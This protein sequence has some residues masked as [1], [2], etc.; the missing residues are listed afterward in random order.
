MTVEAHG[1]KSAWTAQMEIDHSRSRVTHARLYAGALYVLSDRGM[2]AAYDAET[3]KPLWDSAKQIGDPS[4]ACFEPAV[5]ENLLALVNGTRLYVLNRFNGEVLWDTSLTG[6]PATGP[7][8]SEHRVYVPMNA[9]LVT[10]YLLKPLLDPVKDLGKAKAKPKVAEPEPELLSRENFKLAQESGAVL[11]CQSTGDPTSAPVV[12]HKVEDDVV[13]W[14]TN[15]GY[16]FISQ[17]EH[18]V[19]D[20]FTTKFR[21]ETGAGISVAPTYLPPRTSLATRDR[22]II[23]AVSR[24]GR[25]FSIDEKTGE[26]LWQ[27]DAVDPIVQSAAALGDQVFV[28]T[29]L[30]GMHCLD[31][32]SGAQKWWAPD[33][34]QF[35]SMSNNR[36][37][38]ATRANQLLILNASNGARLDAMNIAATPIRVMNQQTDRIYLLS[39]RGAIQCLHEEGLATPLAYNVPAPEKAPKVVEKK[40]VERVK[41]EPSDKPPAE[42]KP[43]PDKP[44]PKAKPAADDTPK[45]A[46]TPKTPKGKKPKKGDLDAGALPSN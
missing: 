14:P 2:I 34:A 7:A 6:C 10:S 9:G 20:H 40:P 29:E 31:A 15:A 25:V 38:A 43:K 18:G 41:H 32:A 22:G 35:V 33:A 24:S 4:M 17:I 5:N 42:K 45:P 39:D 12:L 46:K 26:S 23:F 21:L 11:A 37:Y 8:L 3:G 16:L 44:K 1:L 30:G 36:I 13:A 19:F 27:F 28:T